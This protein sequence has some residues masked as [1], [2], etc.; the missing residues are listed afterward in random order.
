MLQEHSLWKSIVKVITS[1]CLILFSIFMVAFYILLARVF[2]L[3]LVIGETYRNPQIVISTKKIPIPATRGNIYDRLGRPLAI[4]KSVYSIKMDAHTV[5]IDAE[6]LYDL[7]KL[8][9]GK[10]E[11]IVDR[12]PFTKEEPYEFLF[13]GTGTTHDIWKKDMDFTKEEM[14]LDAYESFQKIRK[15]FKIDENLPDK[16]ARKILNLC[17]MLYLQ[18]YRAWEPITI[19]YDVKQD[20]LSVIEEETIK[21]AGFSAEIQS[22]RYYPEGKYFAHIVGYSQKMT[23]EDKDQFP[24]YMDQD[25]VG[26]NGIEYAYETQLRGKDGVALAEITS[27]KKILRYLP[28]EIPA[29]SG[30]NVYLTLDRDL[31]VNAYNIL[32]EM[33]RDAII[34]QIQGKGEIENRITVRQFLSSLFKGVSI[35]IKKV[36]S[37]TGG[38]PSVNLKNYVLAEVSNPDI[39]DPEVRKQIRALCAN[40]ILNGQIPAREVLMIMLEQNIISGGAELHE[41]LA[42]GNVSEQEVILDKLASNEITPQMTNLDPCTGS[43]VVSDINTGSVLAAVSYPSYDTNE[44]VNKMNYD[45]YMKNLEDPTAPSINRPLSERRAP[46]STLKMISAITALES[47]SISLSDRIYDGISFE[48]AGKPFLKCWSSIGHRSIDVI[49][50]LEGSCNFFFCEAI[51]RL[52]N[53]KAGNKLDSITLWNKYISCF[54]LDKKTGVEIGEVMPTVPSPEQKNKTVLA[55]NPDA[56]LYDREWHDGN[57]VQA[58]IGQGFNDYTAA[59]MNKYILTIATRG[60]RYQLNMVDNVRSADGHLIEKTRTKLEAELSDISESTW[61]AVYKGMLLC[62]EGQNGTGTNTFRGFPVR[63]AGKTGTAEEKP[64]RNDHSSFGGFAPYEDPQIAIYVSIPFGNTKAMPALASQIALKVMNEYFGLDK[65]P[66]YPE[67][68][69]SLI[70]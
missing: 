29:V 49:Q 65:E 54:G 6:N 47:G 32:E 68:E 21:Y 69:N 70:R 42:N 1:R 39:Q 60:Q 58:A 20:T 22:I 30:D 16:E 48:S 64:G 67:T 9:E 27:A 52:G 46:G 36:M 4:N 8:L 43:V 26:K 3:Q 5:K 50:A 55:I 28:D 13:Y 23:E 57:T 61:D 40:A 44:Y 11:T 15:K 17:N 31:Q 14:D 7:I 10:G 18:R 33:L 24:H 51:Y 2:Y 63:V 56:P 53:E 34:N 59:N 66:Q 62:I 38:S 25:I 35:D 12:F 37:A 19:A 45:Y 41:Q